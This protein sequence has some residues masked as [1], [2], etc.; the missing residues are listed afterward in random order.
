VSAVASASQPQRQKRLN[1]RSLNGRGAA[2]N[3]AF[4]TAGFLKR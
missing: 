3:F 1:R 2:G 4:F